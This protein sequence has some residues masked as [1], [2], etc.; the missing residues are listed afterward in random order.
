[1]KKTTLRIRIDLSRFLLALLESFSGIEQHIN[2]K[3][4]QR[5]KDRQ[6]DKVAASDEHDS[7]IHGEE[8]RIEMVVLRL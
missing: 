1:M 5:G 4:R 2:C 3:I 6:T 8:L 7:L